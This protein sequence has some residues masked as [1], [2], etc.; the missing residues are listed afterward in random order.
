MKAKQILLPSLLAATFSTAATAQMLNNPWGKPSKADIEAAKQKDRDHLDMIKVWDRLPSHLKQQI[1]NKLSSLTEAQRLALINSIPSLRNLS[2]TQKE[3]LLDKLEQAIPY[4]PPP[5]SATPAVTNFCVRVVGEAPETDPVLISQ[6]I[7]QGYI[8]RSVAIEVYGYQ[9]NTAG[10]EGPTAFKY[11]EIA[12][13]SPMVTY[14]FYNRDYHTIPVAQG[15]ST[16]ITVSV[17]GSLNDLTQDG[18]GGTEFS[19]PISMT[20]VLPPTPYTRPAGQSVDQPLN[21]YPQC[22]K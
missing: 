16:T 4:P 9:Y 11:D 8:P 17:R 15:Q 22:F 6:A 13:I 20:Y 19:A 10:S 1:T 12:V 18:L 2:T 21:L 14:D 7:E 3:M 5:E